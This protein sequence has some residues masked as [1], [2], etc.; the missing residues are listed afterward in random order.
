M[1]FIIEYLKN[2]FA[3]IEVDYGVNPVI[4]AII[5]FGGA[6]FFWLAIYKIITGL[7]NKKIDQVR[8]F[9]IVLGIT[10]IAPFI[11][12][13][14]FGHNVPFWFWVFGSAILIYTFY[15][16]MSRVKKSQD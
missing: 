6:P 12:V 4:F 7:K 3:R 14:I 2:W 11:Y 5:Y 10:T 16:V 13:A 15:N 8:I 1:H 9:G